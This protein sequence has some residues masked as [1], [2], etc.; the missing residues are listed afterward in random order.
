MWKSLVFALYMYVPCVFTLQ[1]L[2]RRHRNAAETGEVI[3]LSAFT[4]ENIDDSALSLF[5]KTHFTL[6]REVTSRSVIQCAS[7]CWE[8]RCDVFTHNNQL[9][10][11]YAEFDWVPLFRTSHGSG[12]NVSHAW[13]YGGVGDRGDFNVALAF[14]PE[15]NGTFRSSLVTS[16]WRNIT[17]VSANYCRTRA[18][19][20][21]YMYSGNSGDLGISTSFIAKKSIFNFRVL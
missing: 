8:T 9:C 2:Y 3:K 16:M 4:R 15:T 21:F 20:V 11:T 19:H 12:A 18:G 6:Q 13:R 7:R 10:K 5:T 14:D 17:Q 1:V